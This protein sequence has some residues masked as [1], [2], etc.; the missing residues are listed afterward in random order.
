MK[1]KILYKYMNREIDMAIFT[2]SSKYIK[3]P[4]AKKIPFKTYVFSMEFLTPG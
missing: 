2:N 4:F 1:D 3:N